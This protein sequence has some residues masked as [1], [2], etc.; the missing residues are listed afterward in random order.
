MNY[1]RFKKLKKFIFGIIICLTLAFAAIIAYLF[2]LEPILKTYI[3]HKA[4]KYHIKLQPNKIGI[5]GAIDISNQ[6]LS[7]DKLTDVFI[8]SAKIR[9]PLPFLPGFATAK[10]IKITNNNFTIIIPTANIDNIAKN[11]KLSTVSNKLYKYNIQDIS[12]PKATIIYRDKNHLEHNINITN[13]NISNIKNGNI[14]SINSDKIYVQLPYYEQLNKLSPTFTSNANV[15]A[16]IFSSTIKNLNLANITYI[17]NGG[18]DSINKQLWQN[19]QASKLNFKICENENCALI[20]RAQNVNIGTF[21][22][23]PF[24]AGIKSIIKKVND[25]NYKDTLNI[26]KHIKKI[27]LS[28]DDIFIHT[29]QS[30]LKL[31][32]LEIRPNNWEKIIP[33]NLLLNFN[34][35]NFTNLNILKDKN[36]LEPAT[37][38]NLKLSAKLKFNYNKAKQNFALDNLDININNVSKLHL[39]F[40]SFNVNDK[41][42]DLDEQIALNLKDNVTL[43]KLAVTYIDGGFIESIINWLSI[44]NN[45]NKEDVQTL[46]YAILEK[47]P[48]LLLHNKLFG[49]IIG[50][51]LL[52]IAQKPQSFSLEATSKSGNGLKFNEFLNDNTA[53]INS[54]NEKMN[55]HI[56]DKY[57]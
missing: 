16:T 24:T 6:F 48:P 49:E 45:L 38:K 52:D 34:N 40:N 54:I 55:L 7:I 37:Y 33:Y 43:H 35:L 47:S 32:K 12:I 3:A 56:D 28:L 8:E 53:T 27:G 18:E 31:D 25:D 51:K 50:A 30:D 46:V 20:L 11:S 23:K 4:S 29:P 41:L 2:Y 26:I 15:T 42:F 21:L 19:I 17:W 57:L 10:N 1:L 5:S 39:S 9:P 14:Q 13:I 22:L 44:K 36:I